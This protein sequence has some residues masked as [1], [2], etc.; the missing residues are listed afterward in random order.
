MYQK[1]QSV[2]Y[3]NGLET[4]IHGIAA[5][6]C[7]EP[8]KLPCSIHLM[9]D[10]ETDQNIEFDLVKDF[11]LECIHILFGSEVTPLDLTEEQFDKLNNYV[12]SI[13]YMISIDR[14]ETETEYQLKIKFDRYRS[15]KPN[16]FE[17]LK[18]YM[19]DN[20]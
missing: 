13:G 11:T 10:H 3:D 17:H 8:P 14:I 19:G 18:K 16:P 5:K 20:S 1:P 9:M 6:I 7:S 15:F 12:K 4:N 2:T